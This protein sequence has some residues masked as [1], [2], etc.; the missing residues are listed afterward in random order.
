MEKTRLR[1][2]DLEIQSFATTGEGTQRRG[3]VRAHDAPT[4][5]VECPTANPNWNTCWD[6]CW[7]TCGNTCGCGGGG[8][9]STGCGGFSDWACTGNCSTTWYVSLCWY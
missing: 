3:T 2:D 1:L 5:E 6:T 4:D 9:D 7:D 8:G